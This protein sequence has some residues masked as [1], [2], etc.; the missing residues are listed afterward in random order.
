[1]LLEGADGVTGSAA[2]G[3]GAEPP[4]EKP[5]PENGAGVGAVVDPPK[6]KQLEAGAAGGVD[7]PPKLNPLEAGAGAGVVD[8]PNEN[9]PEDGAG[10]GVEDPQKLNPED[11]AVV[12]GAG[13]PLAPKLNPPLDG[14]GAGVEDPPKLKPDEGAAEVRFEVEDPLKRPVAA[15][16]DPSSTPPADGVLNNPLDN[17]GVELDEDVTVVFAI[18]GFID[19]RLD[20]A[21]IFL[22]FT[23]NLIR[24]SSCA[25]LR[26]ASKNGSNDLPP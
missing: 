5:P 1:M 18:A 16:F 13:V 6:L 10:V 2:A 14:A 3:A 25:S 22:F 20:L 26:S 4:N 7:E 11:E 19:G 21:F 12:A 23:S 24:F 9:P 8:P 17:A 15:G